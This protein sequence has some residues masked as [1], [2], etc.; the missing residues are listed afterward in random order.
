M[1]T[2]SMTELE[3]WQ[4]GFW[5]TKKTTRGTLVFIRFRLLVRCPLCCDTCLLS[6]SKLWNV[7]GKSFDSYRQRST[8]GLSDF[9]WPHERICVDGLCVRCV[10]IQWLSIVLLLAPSGVSNATD[11]HI[12][13]TCVCLHVKVALLVIEHCKHVALFSF[14]FCNTAQHCMGLTGQDRWAD[15]GRLTVVM[16]PSTC[17]FVVTAGFTVRT[18]VLFSRRMH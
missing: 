5:P 9:I 10:W 3:T 13:H 14:Y 18:V 15:L 6:A 4:R 16:M 2:V 1:K 12:D 7:F 8:E 17:P 11:T